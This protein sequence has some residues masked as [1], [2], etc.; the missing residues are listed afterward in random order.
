MSKLDKKK[1]KIHDRII[2]LE[3]YLKTSLHKKDSSTREIDV[4]K[5]MRQIADL[6]SQLQEA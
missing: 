2:E 3:D 4:P 5:V 6:K 1:L